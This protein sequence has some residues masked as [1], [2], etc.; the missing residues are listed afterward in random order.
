M[1]AIARTDRRPDLHMTDDTND[2]HVQHSKIIRMSSI[3]ENV[4][5][6]SDVC[7]NV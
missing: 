7:R 1:V 4:R 6:R 5:R 3:Y 2:V